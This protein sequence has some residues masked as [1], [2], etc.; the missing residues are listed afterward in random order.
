MIYE[1]DHYM[2]YFLIMRM[3]LNVL[4][5]YPKWFST[6]LWL[7]KILPLQWGNAGHSHHED[8]SSS[9]YEVYMFNEVNVMNQENTYGTPPG[10]QSNGKDIN[11]PSTSTYP[12]SSNPLQIENPIFDAVLHPPK[13]AIRK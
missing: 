7:H 1:E 11:Q 10:D 3:S 6:N 12:P 4:R 13:S 9:V 2:K 5:V 8:A